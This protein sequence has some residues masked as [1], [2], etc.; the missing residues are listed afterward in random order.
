MTNFHGFH[1]N[2]TFFEGW[3]AKYQNQTNTV[4]V[5]PAFHIDK[6]GVQQATLQ[7]ITENFSHV[8][9]FPVQEL[10]IA[11]HKFYIHTKEIILCEK[12]MKVKCESEGVSIY[13]MIKYQPFTVLNSDIMGPFHWIPFMQCNHGVVSLAHRIS[14][15]LEINKEQFD[16]NNG[17]G[18]IEK[19][20]GSSFPKNY[21]WTQCNWSKEHDNCIMMAVADIPILG[22]KEKNNFCFTGCI[23]IVWYE[24]KEYRIATYKGAKVLTCTE[25]EIVVKQGEYQLSARLLEGK[26]FSLRAPNNGSMTRNIHECPSCTVH[27]TFLKNKQPVFDFISKMAGFESVQCNKKGDR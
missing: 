9:S 2:S 26:E 23:C 10:K 21:I 13:G 11:K 19:D 27:Y 12:G 25:K 15:K 18:Y 16:F 7:I 4:A 14:G 22:K 24:R 5:I 6:Y 20:W 3:Y 8:F 17:I 1:K